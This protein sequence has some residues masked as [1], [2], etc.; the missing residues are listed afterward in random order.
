MEQG[1]TEVLRTNARTMS[2]VFARQGVDALAT[3][4]EAQV[5]NHLEEGDHVI[6]LLVDPSMAKRAGNLPGWPKEISTSVETQTT[7]IQVGQRI[8]TAA[9]LNKTLPGGYH[10]LLG[11]DIGRFETLERLFVYGLAGATCIVLLV[12]LAGGLLVRRTLLSKVQDINQAASA[13]IQGNLAHRLPATPG[14]NELN[15][16]V[17]T[18][19]RMLD[20][21]EHLVEGI[22]HVSNAIAHDLR[23]PLAELRSRLEELAVTR[24]P[25]EQAFAEIDSA[26]ADVDRVIGIFNALLRMAEIDTGVRRSGFVQVDASKIA[27]EAAE[28]YQPVAELRG[29]TLSFASSGP[30]QLA[31]DP[32]LLAQAVGNLVDN[33]I[34]YAAQNGNISI[35]TAVR[36]DGT[37]EIAV[38]DD[39]P[40][41]PDSEKPKVFER[42]YRCDASRGTPGAG[43]G[44]SLVAAV[45]RLHGGALSLSDNNP[46]LRATLRFPGRAR[47]TDQARA[48]AANMD[49]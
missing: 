9:L 18:E 14:E 25:A 29:A 45:A 40:G 15:T 36:P 31:G 39:G 46:G 19:N 11:R 32:L 23:T 33:A 20:H 21:I 30:L 27:A 17:A 37:C 7:S 38:A 35:E 13:I 5:G 1:R 6:T 34:K 12:G 2:G 47:V 8:L 22:R 42:F 24:P 4:I 3:A 43:L 49:K 16:L 28:F 44:L 10:L 26:I 48:Q 41:I